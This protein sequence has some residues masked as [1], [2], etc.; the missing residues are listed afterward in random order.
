MAGV[1]EEIQFAMDQAAIDQLIAESQR[2]GERVG[3]QMTEAIGTGGKDA[4]RKA[5]VDIM[6]ELERDLERN[7][8]R[9][10]ESLARGLI[11]ED[12]ARKAAD[13]NARAYNAGI[14]RAM[15][16]LRQKGA[17][18]NEAFIEMTAKLKNVGAA[19]SEVDKVSTSTSKLTS[20][21]QRAGGI[22]A[23][24]F[25]LNR[26]KA[27]GASAIEEFRK[28][29]AALDRLDSALRRMG[30]SADA[31]A[32]QLRQI[33]GEMRTLRLDEDETQEILGT[34]IGRTNQVAESF[35]NVGLVVALARREHMDFGSAAQIVANLMNGNVIRLRQLGIN[36]TNAKDALAELR[37]ET[38]GEGEK[39]AATLTGR[40]TGLNVL[41]GNFKSAIGE[42]MIEAGG[43]SSVIDTLS[44]TIQ[45][46]TKW[47]ME[48]HEAIRAFK[49]A[50]VD[51][52]KS[53]GDLGKGMDDN[54]VSFTQFEK[55]LNDIDHALNRVN[56]AVTWFA[57]AVK[58]AYGDLTQL[59]SFGLIGKA[60]SEDG[61][62]IMAEGDRLMR[63]AD[64]RWRATLNRIAGTGDRGKVTP[65]E[66]ESLGSI[67]GA[68]ESGVI[69]TGPGG[70]G[71]RDAIA[72]AAKAKAAADALEK[73]HADLIQ[74]A[75]KLAEVES[76][77]ALG[78]RL[79]NKEEDDLKKQLDSG[80]LSLNDRVKKL[81]QLNDV[82]KAIRENQNKLDPEF[83]KAMN[84][85]IDTQLGIIQPKA[86]EPTAPADVIAAVHEQAAHATDNLPTQ[87]PGVKDAF[88]DMLADMR[89]NSA[90]VADDIAGHFSDAF[91]QMRK[92]GFTLNS[93]LSNLGKGLAKSILGEIQKVAKGE[94]LQALANAIK[95]TAIGIGQ[96][97]TG[98]P[99]AGK[100]FAA[101][102]TFAKS[103]IAWGAL[104][105]SVGAI[106][107]GGAGGGD[108][109][110]GGGS[111]NDRTSTIDNSTKSGPEIHI[112]L[113]GVDSRNPRHQEIIGDANRRWMETTGGKIIYHPGA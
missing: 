21:L 65:G 81:Q 104:A 25:A 32:P 49:D 74:N 23:G 72:E 56:A 106:G 101:A 35:K 58:K 92:D 73:A 90:D 27:F 28:D 31:L 14:M 10:K 59:I 26:I 43:G 100:S 54:L 96:A 63:D 46:M 67:R 33:E 99:N 34:L 57:G 45:T 112:Y 95:F 86:G 110:S 89:E 108:S 88:D 15:D 68:G 16:Q 42:A 20:L 103:A 18:T 51:L 12:G 6:G 38:A 93:V 64:S 105:G 2:T 70:G 5:A 30:T 50:I 13:A 7:E 1:I 17:L 82:E 62:R 55:D 85:S 8:A 111:T 113:D 11:S 3:K 98:N 69:P 77:R 87:F 37:K 52:I 94:A 71:G 66:G 22:M 78:L 102:G 79:L 40:L 107:G 29:E 97:A 80:T 60:I 47:V 53:L 24:F 76:T 9:V 44:A 4:A 84:N 61:E 48:N 19:S 109:G 39:W 41:W 83:V 91:A 75:M 36:A